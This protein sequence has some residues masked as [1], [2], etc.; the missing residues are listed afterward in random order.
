MEGGVN[1]ALTNNTIAPF[2]MPFFALYEPEHHNSGFNEGKLC[3]LCARE[4]HIAN[5]CAYLRRSHQLPSVT[6]CWKHP[7]VLIDTCPNCVEPL[8]KTVVLLRNPIGTCHCGWDAFDCCYQADVAS[9]IEQELA[10]SAHEM[11]RIRTSEAEPAD[12]VKF[13]VGQNSND[14][15]YHAM[16]SRSTLVDHVA[17]QLALTL[18]SVIST[19]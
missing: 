1:S 18:R 2:L 10:K 9:S 7:V 4:D 15:R 16:S 6:A 13:F 12:L 17:D 19:T 14:A 5:S 8:A 11:L 3:L